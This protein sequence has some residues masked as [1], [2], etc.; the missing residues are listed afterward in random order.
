MAEYNRDG[1]K[2]PEFQCG[3]M[4]YMVR[5]V[6]RRD[7]RCVAEGWKAVEATFGRS[8]E[9]GNFGR[10]G[11]PHGGPSGVAFWLAELDQAVLV[12]RERIGGEVQGANRAARAEDSQGPRWLAGRVAKPG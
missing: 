12:S 2:S 7:E 11:T 1:F 5:A 8:T 6:V 4:H 9:A 10:K 3:A